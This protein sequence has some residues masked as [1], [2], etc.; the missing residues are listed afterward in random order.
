VDD[1][2][3][4]KTD[5]DFK[6]AGMGYAVDAFLANWDVFGLVFDNC[7]INSKTGQPFRLDAGG[8]L[9]F[10]AQ[11]APKGDHLFNGD[12]VP[13]LDTF[14]QIGNAAKVYTRLS[15]DEVEQSLEHFN[16][17]SLDEI[18]NVVDQVGFDEQTN[19]KMKDILTGRYNYINSV[20]MRK[21]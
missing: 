17:V 7:F 20:Q 13:E 3:P 14:F 10:R 12:S 1:L 18:L 4:L 9:L 11:G 5:E 16:T 15:P 8:A 19:K 2:K 6:K 21:P